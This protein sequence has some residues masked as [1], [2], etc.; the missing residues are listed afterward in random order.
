MQLVR[1]L[2]K[3]H[4]TT[5][6]K[7]PKHEET[8][9]QHQHK[10]KAGGVQ[11]WV[12]RHMTTKGSYEPVVMTCFNICNCAPFVRIS[13]ETPISLLLSTKSLTNGECY[14]I[15]SCLKASYILNEF[16]TNPVTQQKRSL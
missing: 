6:I 15:S 10:V 9:G 14:Y 4:I 2:L 3:M 12:S 11:V 7:V 13:H 16:P 5:L 1:Q 8:I